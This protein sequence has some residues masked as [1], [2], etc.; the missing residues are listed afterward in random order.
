VRKITSLF[1]AAAF[2][3]FATSSFAAGK[4][5]RD[6]SGLTVPIQNLIGLSPDPAVSN[7]TTV[8]KTK[9]TIVTITNNAGYKGIKWHAVSAA[10]AD[11]VVKRK[12]NSNTAFMPEAGGTVVLNGDITT[13]GFD[14]YSTNSPV[15]TTVCVE[16]Q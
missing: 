16:L 7:C 12:L 8:T 2:L 1:L 4:L 15:A 9:G 6:T 14:L 10:G 11:I 5:P 3:A 13:A